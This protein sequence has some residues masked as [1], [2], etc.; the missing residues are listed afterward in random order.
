MANTSRSILLQAS[1]TPFR[2]FGTEGGAVHLKAGTGALK[3]RFDL[4]VYNGGPV[5]LPDIE[6]PVILDLDTLRQ[7]PTVQMLANHRPAALLGTAEEILINRRDYVIEGV[8]EVTGSCPEAHEVRLNAN[9]GI[10][11]QLSYGA[12]TR[13]MHLVAD[14]QSVHVNGQDWMGPVY[15]ARNALL[16]EVSFVPLGADL[17][18]AAILA[19]S[20]FGDAAMTLE[21]WVASMG[22]DWT[23]LSEDAKAVLQSVYDFEM[24]PEAIEAEIAALPTEE[25]KDKVLTARMKKLTAARVQVKT[26]QKTHPKKKTVPT[27]TSTLPPAN[28][29]TSVQTLT[30]AHV[31]EEER[32]GGIRRLNLKYGAPKDG[33]GNE[34]HLTAM[35]DGWN[36]EKTELEMLRH[37]RANVP[38]GGNPA[39]GEKE[40]EFKLLEAALMQT[41]RVN[42]KH[43]KASFT[44]Q[45]LEQAHAKYKSRLG[46][47]EVIHLAAQLNGYNHRFSKNLFTGGELRN[48]L[49]SAFSTQDLSGL[50]SA[51]VNKRLLDGYELVEDEWRKI[52]AIGSV[53]D[54]KTTTSYRPF[55][56][57]LA[58]PLSPTG[59]IEHAEMDEQSYTNQAATYARMYA[60]TRQ[61]QIND[62]LGALD[63]VP[64]QLG[65]GQ[66]LKIAYEF[67]KAFLATSPTF[68]D[69]SNSN[70]S[71]GVFG[72]AGLQ[73]AELVFKNMKDATG[74]FIGTEPRYLVVPPS[75]EVAA[76]QFYGDANL[77]Y[78]GSTLTPSSNPYKG[79]F[80]PVVSRYLSDSRLTG[81]SA[82]KY[83]LL[84]D[85]NDVATIEV[86][87]LNGNQTPYVETAEVDFSQLGIQMRTY[88]DWGIKRQDPKGGVQ[89]SGA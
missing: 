82:V 68:W 11:Y 25:E 5:T 87:F 40:T 50:M 60:I 45:V 52:A 81:Y 42:E 35:R 1:A 48:L 21:E 14:G 57:F 7:A 46:L 66:G 55:G 24:K 76:L 56:D 44:P 37:G 54:F 28:V 30:A 13:E 59:H 53:S 34:I 65:R 10:Q 19:A 3:N 36:L 16:Y 27:V 51:T 71:T 72:L 17:T 18:S 75:L 83:Y 80:E 62:D 38:T 43:L 22:I 67:W 84:A 64:K 85:P 32:L 2:I 8:G 61:D 78:G 6:Y 31:A 49:A 88:W 74:E 39:M 23:A 41:C 26:L 29:Q 33:T 15:V 63:S 12:S 79:K 20:L 69:A 73:A 4:Q 70:V 58:K 86:V 47:Q 77:A 89:S 9:N